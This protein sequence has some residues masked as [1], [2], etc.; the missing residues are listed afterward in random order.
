[1]FKA[2]AQRIARY[3]LR[4]ELSFYETECTKLQDELRAEND[5][6]RIELDN[7]DD[8]AREVVE[9]IKRLRAEKF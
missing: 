2:L 6:L 7:A 1:M 4:D 5:N 8:Y 3:V 9:E